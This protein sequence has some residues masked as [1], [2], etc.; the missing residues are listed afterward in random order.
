MECQ[1]QVPDIPARYVSDKGMLSDITR[2]TPRH[3]RRPGPRRRALA[4]RARPV[5]YPG[6]RGRLR[7]RA[8]RA[9]NTRQAYRAA[10][11]A[12]DGIGGLEHW[13]AG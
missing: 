11:A 2:R 5:G 12:F 4:R 10:L 6:A 3:D 7:P 1:G 8:V 13:I 9:D